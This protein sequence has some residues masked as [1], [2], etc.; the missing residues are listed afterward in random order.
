M[1]RTL[2][3]ALR[4]R[5]RAIYAY[6]AMHDAWATAEQ[7]LARKGREIE[8]AGARVMAQRVLRAW[9]AEVEDPEPAP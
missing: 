3:R 8:A 7:S 5:E 4:D 1:P 2:T 6:A 9:L